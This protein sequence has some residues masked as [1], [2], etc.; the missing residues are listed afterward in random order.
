MTLRYGNMNRLIVKRKT[1]LG[2]VLAKEEDE[3]F[4]HTNGW[5]GRTLEVDEEVNAFLYFDHEGRVAASLDIPYITTTDC[6]FVKVIGVDDFGVFVDIGIRRDVLLSSDDLPLNKKLWPQ[7]DDE[8]YAYLKVDRNKALLIKL[9]AKEDFMDIKVDADQSLFGKQID[10]RPFRIGRE[11]INVISPEGYLGFIH[12]TAYREEPRLGGLIK[13]RVT[14]VKDDGEI[15]LSLIPQKEI[16]ITKDAERIVQYLSE[17]D[18]V[19]TLTDRST[20]DEIRHIFNMSK[21]A[22]K[23]A[24]GHLLKEKKIE[25][26]LEKGLT[27]LKN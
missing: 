9:A 24:M 6:D 26:D 14:F 13:A 25:Q 16:L 23:R 20:P 2:Y 12:H 21:S 4:L 22:F 8:V 27:R 3:V 17:H 11:G 19:M 15:N 10:V 18:G 5:A 1:D 7:V